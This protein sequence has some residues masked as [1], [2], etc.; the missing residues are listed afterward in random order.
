MHRKMLVFAIFL[1]ILSLLAG[2]LAEPVTIPTRRIPAEG[3]SFTGEDALIRAEE[4]F[5]E[6]GCMYSEENYFRKAGSV[7]L[8][9][10]RPVWIVIIERRTD[11]ASGNLYAV[12]SAENGET[13][14][15]VYPENDVYTWLLFQW[16]DMKNQYKSDWPVEDQALFDSLFSESDDPFDP[17][18][19]AVSSDEAIRIASAW[20]AEHPGTEYDSTGISYIGFTENNCTWYDWV[21]SFMKNERQ[22]LVVWVSTET[23]EIENS[24]DAADGIG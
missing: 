4:L 24:F 1:L 17:S 13:V 7:L 10:G 8:P 6:Q 11:Q 12:L 22:V 2:S 3:L 5:A 9:D 18:R 20:V 21:I 19:A 14:E 16:T 23:G 15:L